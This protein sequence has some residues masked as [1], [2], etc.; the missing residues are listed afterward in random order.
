[1]TINYSQSVAEW[2]VPV[3]ASTTGKDAQRYRKERQDCSLSEGMME[4][5]NVRS[6]GVCC[7]RTAENRKHITD[8]GNLSFSIQQSL[9]HVRYLT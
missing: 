8:L 1:M 4:D 6:T 3:K 9:F 2:T 5:E 7:S